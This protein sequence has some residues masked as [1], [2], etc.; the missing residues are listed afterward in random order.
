[1]CAMMVGV[2]IAMTI[3]VTNDSMFRHVLT[4]LILLEAIAYWT[5]C[6]SEPGIPENIL[7]KA[8]DLENLDRTNTVSVNND[9][10]EW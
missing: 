2:L 5:L 4:G 6:F 1:M 10:D 9:D 3:S 8:A 7:K